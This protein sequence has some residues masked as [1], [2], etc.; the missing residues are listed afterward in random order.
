MADACGEVC[1]VICGDHHAWDAARLDA[2][3]RLRTGA[4]DSG[5]DNAL[6]RRLERD[7]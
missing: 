4:D 2:V 5:P 3:T 6:P 1:D 7:V